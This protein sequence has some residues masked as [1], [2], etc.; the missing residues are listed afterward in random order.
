MIKNEESQGVTHLIF[1]YHGFEDKPTYPA[2]L[3]IGTTLS[4]DNIQ[5]IEPLYSNLTLRMIWFSACNTGGSAGAQELYERMARI[6]DCYIV[7]QMLAVPG[8]NSHQ[9]PCRQRGLD[10]DLLQS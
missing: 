6:T 1:N 2:H 10:A 3:A 7:T 4:K 9:L 5:L 8:V